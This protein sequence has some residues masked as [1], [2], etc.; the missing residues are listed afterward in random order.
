MSLVK[1]NCVF[2]TKIIE[3]SEVIYLINEISLLLSANEISLLGQKVP[4]T[5]LLAKRLAAKQA[6]AE[7]LLQI[8]ISVDNY[9][10]V[11]ILHDDQGKPYFYF[12]ESLNNLLQQRYVGSIL[13]SIAD[14]K[15]KA[16]AYVVVK[17]GTN[18]YG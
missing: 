2:S 14:E 10:L 11:S 6:L 3:I 4:T 5:I 17:A 15:E 8:N 9:S 13:L 16:Y 7:C 18:C 12:S 1:P